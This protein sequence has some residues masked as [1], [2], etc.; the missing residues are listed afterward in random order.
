M[1]N[2]NILWWRW[3]RFTTS[4]ENATISNIPLK[5]PGAVTFFAPPVEGARQIVMGGKGADIVG[6]HEWNLIEVGSGFPNDVPPFI[7]C[8][9]EINDV[10]YFEVF[11]QSRV[12]PPFKVDLSVVAQNVPPFQPAPLLITGGDTIRI[13][14][15]DGNRL[16]NSDRY[17]LESD[18]WGLKI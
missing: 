12:T 4:V 5:I 17:R 16:N 1:G 18:L 13:T 14:F 15:T 2:P 11:W 3:G 8:N 6:I 10:T 7:F 9:L